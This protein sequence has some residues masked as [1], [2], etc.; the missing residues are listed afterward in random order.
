MKSLN[1]SWEAASSYTRSSY[2]RDYVDT[3]INGLRE[4][5]KTTHP[6]LLP[7]MKGIEHAVISKYPQCRYLIQG[8]N[9]PLDWYCV[10]ILEKEVANVLTSIA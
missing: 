7:V 10:S 3:L 2:G 1:D 9:K 8:S 5:G 4:C 6:T